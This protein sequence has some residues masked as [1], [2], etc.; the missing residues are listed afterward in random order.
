MLT[1]ECRFLLAI[2]RPGVPLLRR[3]RPATERSTPALGNARPA[4][5]DILDSCFPSFRVRQPEVKT[6]RL[7][8]RD[9]SMLQ[10][11][12]LIA[13]ALLLGWMLGP[14]FV[15]EDCKQKRIASSQCK[16]RCCYRAA[17][18]EPADRTEVSTSWLPKTQKLREAPR[19]PGSLRGRESYL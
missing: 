9:L 1:T 2:W 6:A 12:L 10:L 3:H 18:E 19:Q 7:R 15:A 13:V 16:A 4:A 8:S 5:A 17:G 11:I 14:P